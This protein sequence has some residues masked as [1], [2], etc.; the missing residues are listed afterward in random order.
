MEADHRALWVLPVNSAWTVQQSFSIWSKLESEELPR[1]GSFVSCT[2][3]KKYCVI[4]S[5]SS[6]S[7]GIISCLDSDV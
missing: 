4:L 2:E 1:S 7:S 5:F 6:M 3:S